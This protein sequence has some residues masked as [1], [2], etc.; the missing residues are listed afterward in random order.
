MDG[1]IVDFV[2]HWLNY[3]NLFEGIDIRPN[4]VTKWN[5]HETHAGQRELAKVPER[6][7]KNF[8]SPFQMPG[9]FRTAPLMPGTREFIKELQELES[10]EAFEFYIVTSP[11]G[12]VSTKEK[13]EWLEGSF[14][15]VK[16]VVTKHKHLIHGDILVDDYPENVRDWLKTHPT[17][18][19]LIP[20]THYIDNELKRV[21]MDYHGPNHR[22]LCSPTMFGNSAIKDY[23]FFG[24]VLDEVEDLLYN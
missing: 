14:G 3:L 9:F 8:I 1:V 4:E 2:P 5:L 21:G 19:C 15:R 18:R 22:T 16:T 7:V 23:L 11:S 17:G 6:T 10:K 20:A 13:I 24:Q 12:A